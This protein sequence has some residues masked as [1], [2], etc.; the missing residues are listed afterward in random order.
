M[1]EKDEAKLQKK[2]TDKEHTHRTNL[3]TDMT[4]I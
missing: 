4:P 1:Y 2:K 3:D